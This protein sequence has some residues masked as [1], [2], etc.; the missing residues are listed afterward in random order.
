MNLEEKIEQPVLITEKTKL[1][2]EIYEE[3]KK[4]RDSK[5][6]INWYEGKMLY[7]FDKYDLYD[8]LFGEIISKNAFFSE[9]DTPRS[10]FEFKRKL[11]EFY[12]V[13]EGF[14]FKTLQ[15][16]NTKKLHRALPFIQGKSKKE[17]KKVIDLAEREKESL[18]D[19]LAMI[20]ATPEGYCVHEERDSVV[21]EKC[22]KCG[23]ILGSDHKH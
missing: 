1:A 3:F 5:D 12:V 2:K 11:Y 17:I 4:M 19:F 8:F 20:G 9:I 21:V 16:A 10:T 7:F 23:K 6:M 22:K 15:H 13:Q 18:S 14:T